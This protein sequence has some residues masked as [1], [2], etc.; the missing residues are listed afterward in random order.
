MISKFAL[1][2]LL[3][4]HIVFY[5]FA[6]D[7]LIVIRGLNRSQNGHSTVVKSD[8]WKSVKFAY[9]TQVTCYHIL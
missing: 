2:F 8:K 3:N 6:D 4:N 5:Q 9:Y 7:Q 1:I